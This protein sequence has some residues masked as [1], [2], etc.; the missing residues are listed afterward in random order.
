MPLDALVSLVMT[1]NIGIIVERLGGIETGHR[2]LLDWI[3]EW[4][5]ELTATD[6]PSRRARATR[7]TPATSS[8][9][10]S[11]SY[12]EVYGEGEPTVLPAADVVDH[13]LAPLEDADP[14]PCPALPRGH[15][16]RARQRPLGPAR[17]AAYDEREFAADALAVM[18]ATQT[19]RAVLVC[20]SLGAQR[21]LLLAAEHPGARR[22]RRLHRPGLRRRRRAAARADAS[23][24]STTELDTDEGWAKYNRHYWLRDYRDFLEFFFAQMFTEPHSTKPIEDAVGWGLETTPRR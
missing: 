22:G 4:L 20:F 10:A 24:T 6:A 7:T 3:D 12:Y 9:T 8:A 2:E 16:R 23:T 17:A 15:L 5:V 21:A 13:P 18:D 11:A 14:V 1:F 19:E